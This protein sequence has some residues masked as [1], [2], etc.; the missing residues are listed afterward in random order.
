MSKNFQTCID[1]TENNDGPPLPNTSPLCEDLVNNTKYIQGPICA[2]RTLDIE[3]QA[4]GYRPYKE[5]MSVDWVSSV[6]TESSLEK[7]ALVITVHTYEVIAY[8]Q[9]QKHH[10]Q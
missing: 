2:A 5:K 3:L 8:F 7:W 6:E 1:T 9:E 10:V 4:A